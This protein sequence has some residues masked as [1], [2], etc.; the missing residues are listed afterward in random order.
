MDSNEDPDV[1]PETEQE[2]RDAM[3]Q[4][5]RNAAND[6]I[7]DMARLVRRYYVN[8]R[9]QGFS[10]RQ[11]TMFTMIVFQKMVFGS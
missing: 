1:S 4:G 9:A 7:T 6:S 8:F 11:S 10:R 2:I 5:A 3:N